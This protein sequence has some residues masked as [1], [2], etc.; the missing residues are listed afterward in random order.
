MSTIWFVKR[1]RAAFGTG[2]TFLQH[3]GTRTVPANEYTAVQ[4]ILEGKLIPDE[5]VLKYLT[6]KY[7]NLHILSG[8]LFRNGYYLDRHGPKGNLIRTREPKPKQT[9]HKPKPPP[10]PKTPKH[11][12]MTPDEFKNFCTKY[13]MQF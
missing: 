2:V 12:S 1:Y 13:G 3:N 7:E 5:W 6:D 4:Q 9:K 10:I 8:H 11:T